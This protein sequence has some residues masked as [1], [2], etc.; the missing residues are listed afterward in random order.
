MKLV[1]LI[2]GSIGTFFVAV[3]K[4]SRAAE[5]ARNQKWKQAQAMYR[6]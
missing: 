2:V 4:A 1:K 6:D 5:L 3:S